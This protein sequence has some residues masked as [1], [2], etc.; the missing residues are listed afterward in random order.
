MSNKLFGVSK[1]SEI[2][3]EMRQCIV[4]LAGERSW[5]ETRV[6]WLERAARVAGISYRA[7]RALYYCEP[8]DP[9]ASVVESVRAAIQK[10]NSQ[11]EASGRDEYEVLSARLRDLENKFAE[12]GQDVRR[13]AP[14]VVGNPIVEAERR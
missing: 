1:V 6:R 11:A 10:R 14:N 8:H 13:P 4:T 3:T 12:M 5:A 9:R 7:A 2:A